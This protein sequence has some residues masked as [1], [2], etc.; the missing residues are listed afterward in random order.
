MARVP[1]VFTDPATGNTYSWPLNHDTED[2]TG[3]KR[4][5]SHSAPTNAIGLNR[6]SSD[7]SPLILTWK[8]KILQQSQLTAM[9]SWWQI[10]ESRSIY[11]QDFEGNKYEV[12]I[13]DFEATRVRM[14][15]NRRDLVKMPQHIYEYTLQMEVLAILAGVWAG[16]TP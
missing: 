15:L 8:G 6:Q 9:L 4:N 16:V 11:I 3:K 13:V 5:V 1:N 14:A 10:C 2:Q 7:S 12:I